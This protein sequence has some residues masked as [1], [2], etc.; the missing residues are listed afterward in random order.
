MLAEAPASIRSRAEHAQ[1]LL[2]DRGII[3]EIVESAAA[4]GA[5]AFPVTELPSFALALTGRAE[6]WSER[7]RAGNP[8]VI[9]R[10]LDGR[11]LLDLRTVG[12][13]SIASLVDAVVLANG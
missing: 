2:R 7:L 13:E 11:L 8:P 3:V 9:G 4:V 10:V 12:E 6:H 5:G 1:A